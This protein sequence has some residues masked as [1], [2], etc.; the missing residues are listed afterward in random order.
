[1]VARASRSR[2]APDGR[3]ERDP[4]LY[5]STPGRAADGVAGR[6]LPRLWLG[7]VL[8]GLLWLLWMV[9]LWRSYAPQRPVASQQAEEDPFAAYRVQHSPPQPPPHDW[10]FSHRAAA[11]R[12]A[13]G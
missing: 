8:A 13:T 4:L 2:A 5:A 11:P 10:F 7:A 1:M 12:Y 6:H 9:L 3:R